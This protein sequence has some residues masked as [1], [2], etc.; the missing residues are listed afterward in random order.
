MVNK[1]LRWTDQSAFD[2]VVHSSDKMEV[3]KL[4]EEH[5]RTLCRRVDREF[6]LLMIAQWV[7]AIICSVMISPQVWFDGPERAHIRIWMAVIMGGV[8]CSLPLYFAILRPGEKIGRHAI[9]IAQMAF[10]SLFIH[11]MGGRL[12][13]HFH[14]FGSLA[15]LAAYREWSVLVTGSLV[16]VTDHLIRGFFYP[17]SV[18]GVASGAEWRWLEH[19]GW[20]L[21]EDVFLA[22]ACIHAG[23]ETWQIAVSKYKLLQSRLEAENLNIRRTQF[24]SVVSHEIRTP[25]NGI[26]GFT[27]FLQDSPIP[28]EQKE[29]VNIIKQ[30]SD[31]L[32][33]VL[34]DFL[35][36]TKIDSGRLEIDPHKFRVKDVTGYLETVFGRQCKNKN[37]DFDISVESDIPGELFGDSHRIRQV[38]TNIV[39]NAIKFTPGGEIKVHLLRSPEREGHYTWE[40][41]DTG[42]GIKEDNLSKIFS[43]FTQENSSTARAYGGTGLGLAISKKLVELMGGN[44]EVKSTYGKG[45]LFVFTIPLA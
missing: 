43:P 41:Y 37:I 45:S 2:Q 38:L 24:F 14:V 7:F 40:I 32:L 20:I 42:I 39:S 6:A 27:D 16:I 23:K 5:K 33:K 17:M 4:Y 26:I 19:A 31:S 12:E 22:L 35:D 29:Y 25:L 11:L 18:Y 9:A 34:N 8:I 30:C 28:D 13:A 15:F 10:S 3:T 21:F 36:F 44:I 1:N